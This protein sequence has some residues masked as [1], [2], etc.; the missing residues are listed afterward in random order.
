MTTL[1]P[2]R[3]RLRDELRITERLTEAGPSFV[4]KDPSSGA[5]FQLGE[6]E[7]FIAR[8]LDGD[9]PHEEIARRTA[10]RFE[11]A[12][13]PEEVAAFVEQL[14]RLGLLAG[15]SAAPA[16]PRTRVRGSL[17]YLRFKAFDPDRTLARLVRR[18]G[19]IYTVPFAVL[20]GALVLIALAVAVGHRGEILSDAAGLYRFD[21]IFLAWLTVLVVT[22]GHEFAHGITC[23]RFGGEVHEM[24]FM[25]IYFQPAMY[26]NVSDAWLFP[27]RWKRLAVTFAG[28]Y[29]EVVVWALAVLAWRATV[30]ATW[31]SD[32]ALIVVFSSGFKIFFNLNPLIKLDGYYLLSD[33][34]EIPNLRGRSARYLGRRLRRLLG[35]RDAAPLPQATPRE[36]RI[37]V[38]YALLAI[39]FSYWLLGSFAVFAARRLGARFGTAGLILFAAIVVAATRGTIM[40][41]FRSVAARARR[42]VGQLLPTRRALAWMILTAAA[43]AGAGS[44]SLPLR[45]GGDAVVL[46]VRN[47]GAHAQVEGIVEA[48]LVAEGERV[49][50][51]QPIA[52]LSARDHAARLLMTEAA[53]AELSARLRLLRTGARPEELELARIAVD[54]VEERLRF[55]A[56][57]LQRTRDLANAGSSSPTELEGADERVAVLT[58]EADEARA[59]L[60]A[61][62]AGSRPEEIESAEAEIAR[63]EA[64]RRLI[65]EQL[66][67][68]VVT[69]PVAGVVTTRRPAERVGTRLQPGDTLLRIAALDTV[70]AEVAVDEAR[71]ADVRVGQPATLRLRAYPDADLEGVVAGIAATTSADVRAARRDVTVTLRLRGSGLAL[72]PQMTGYARIYCGERRLGSLARRGLARIVRLEIWA[73]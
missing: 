45:V 16:R 10:S 55:A 19:I 67:L 21:A 48:V 24:G 52:R 58:R 11:S 13:P 3:P 65:V 6:V 23:K 30:P 51:G 54:K 20:S 69:S 70:L 47:A 29:F 5:F 25:L 31:P 37:Y 9:T 39:T 22:W 27:E 4:V 34:L 57:H 61:L 33:L 1:A 66:G 41:A 44:M 62:L 43:L 50:V 36:A 59:R 63:S 46:P 40:R 60:A 7:H 18:V 32:L 56:S 35:G 53:L 64:E 17:V 49:R 12:P 8:Q 14:G 72:R 2:D 68:L 38:V 73:W 42:G 26:C 15:A 71:I 28:A